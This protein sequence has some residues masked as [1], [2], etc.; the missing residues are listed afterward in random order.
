L[1]ACH[2]TE[3]AHFQSGDVPFFFILGQDAISVQARAAI[4]RKGQ[5]MRE[6]RWSLLRHIP[7]FHHGESLMIQLM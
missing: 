7:G 6:H 2:N 1:T 3:T 4:E 5:P